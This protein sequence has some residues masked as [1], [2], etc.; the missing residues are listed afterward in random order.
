MSDEMIV[1]LVD[2]ALAHRMIADEIEGPLADVMSAGAFVG[3]PQV[4]AFEREFAHFSGRQHCVGVGNGTDAIE[5]ALRAA[6]VTAGDEVVLPV[7]TFAATAEAVLWAGATP[8]FVDV[9]PVHLL[10]DPA[11]AADAIGPRTRALLPVHLYGQMAPMEPLGHLTERHDLLLLEDAAQ[12]QGASQGGRPVGSVGLAAA[13]SFYPGKNLGAYGDA[14]AVLT[15]EV[16]VADRVR[17]LANHGSVLKYRHDA[18][19]FNSRLD[20]IQAVVL[21]A[22]L[23]HLA[24][25]NAERRRAAHFYQ[26][27]LCGVE[28]IGLPAT[29][30]GNDHV[31]HLFVIRVPDRDRVAAQMQAAGIGVGVHYPIP[32]HLQGAFADL[33]HLPGQFPVAEKA[34]PELL[35]LPIYPGI[36][37]EQQEM[38]ASALVACLRRHRP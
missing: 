11:A 6:G 7:N 16:A 18:P 9:D 38:V 25:C 3:G 12:A 37:L 30:P 2:L 24:Q 15:D 19:G 21:R 1:P 28:D 5:L 27:L 14:G 33:G 26:E 17:C 4:N 13:T 36:S 23:R 20:A 22:K 35:S 10:M 34:A 31:W 29:V 8:V 32:L